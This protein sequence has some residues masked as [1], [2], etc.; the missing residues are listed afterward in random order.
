MNIESA[1]KKDGITVIAP[2]DSESVNEI[3]KSVSESLLLAF[4]N[5]GFTFES[6]YKRFS[7]IKMYMADIPHGLSEASYFY[8]NN[9]IYFRDGMGLADLKKFAVHECIHNLQEVTDEKGNL[10]RLGLCTFKGSKVFGMALNEAAVQLASS[11]ILG[12]TFENVTYYGINF[13]TISP[14]CYPLLCNLI[15][16]MA[17]ATGEE[18]LF[19][20]VLNSSDYF[21]NKFVALCGENVYNQIANSFDKILELEEKIIILQNKLQ[22][23]DLSSSRADSISNKIKEL[24]ANIKNTYFSTQ[25]LFIT[26]YFS[27]IFK[28]LIT[29]SDLDRFRKKLYNFQELAGN[30][31]NYYF[32]NNFYIAM[33]EKLDKRFDML[34]ELDSHSTYLIPRKESTFSKIIK[35]IQKLLL[36]REFEIDKK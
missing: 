30:T 1:L 2:L 9:S 35:Y 33:M 17:Y 34:A 32:F 15:S 5:F 18:V 16:Q 4:P 14:N 31:D 3:A 24:K 11:N 7:S 19:D 25:E 27:T 10:S 29:S 8:K 20:S 22:S 21:R 6:L 13:S 28:S 26:T 36:K 23:I 12:S